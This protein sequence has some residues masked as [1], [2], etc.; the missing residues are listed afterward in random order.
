MRYAPLG[1]LALLIRSSSPGM[2][3]LGNIAKSRSPSS[4]VIFFLRQLGLPPA[5]GCQ[6]A[7]ILYALR[8]LHRKILHRVSSG[9]ACGNSGK[10][11]EY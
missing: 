10:G 8:A 1:V 7:N 3:K 6:Y 4:T 11:E 2:N 9:P 5:N